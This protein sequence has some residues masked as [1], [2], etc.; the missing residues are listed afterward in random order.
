[1][2]SR[3]AS[4]KVMLLAMVA[5]SGVCAL[6]AGDNFFVSGTQAAVP[7]SLATA[8]APT[9]S[10]AEQSSAT[11][12]AAASS[13]TSPKPRVAGRS[14][15]AKASATPSPYRFYPTHFSR[16]AELYY[17]L[18]WGVDS[19]RVKYGESGEIVRFSYRVLDPEKAAPLNEKKIEP[20]LID[21]RAGVKLVVPSLEFVGLLRQSGPPQAGRVYWIAFSNKGRLVRPGDHVNMVI[22]GFRADGLVVE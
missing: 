8:S 17:R 6:G 13:T 20:S 3:T 1:M 7:A 19:L 5:A 21:L 9:P 10:A 14:A 16:R 22:G 2:K 12:P 4:G 18:Y 15:G 11:K